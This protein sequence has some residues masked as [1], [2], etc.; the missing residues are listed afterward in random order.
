MVL[1]I[2]SNLNEKQKEAVLNGDGRVLVLSG[3]GSGKT[4]VIT[5]RIAYLLLEKKVSPFSILS[6]TFT[7]KAATEMKERV[8][9]LLKKETIPFLWI[10][11]FHS[12]CARILREEI[13]KL[14]IGLNRHFTI[15]DR[16]DTK[17]LIKKIM[18]EEGLSVDV[19]PPSEIVEYFSKLKKG[20]S[21]YNPNRIFDSLY[22]IYSK[23]LIEANGVDFDDLLLYTVQLL[24]EIKEVREKYQERFHYILVDEYQDT[25]DI[26]E[27][28]LSILSDKWKNLFLVGDEDQS[29]YSFRGSKVRHIVEFP[30]R[31]EGVK[32][33][34]LE[35][36]YRSYDSIL[37]AASTLVA[38]NTERLGKTLWTDRKGGERINLFT[39]FSDREEANFV[40]ET[41]NILKKNYEYKQITILMRTNAQSRIIEDTFTNKGIPYQIL[42]GIK[43]YERKEIKDI[44]AYIKVAI[45]HYDRVSLFRIINTPAR[46]IG[47]ATIDEIEKI[48][49]QKNL[50]FFDTI[51]NCI[52]EKLLSLRAASILQDFLLLL[53]S[54]SKKIKESKPS[55]VVEWLIK[56][57]SYQDY[58]ESQ[59]DPNKE[60]RIE[61][62]WQLV[63]AL[64]EF[65]EKEGS[66]FESFLEKQA[67]QSDQDELNGQTEINDTVKVM[68]IHSAKGLEFP[69][70]F[71]IGVEDG[72]FPHEFSKN[73]AVEIE[74]ERRL[75]YVGM[76]RSMDKLYLTNTKYRNIYGNIVPRIPSPFLYE[77][78]EKYIQK[79]SFGYGDEMNFLALF[80][81][82]GWNK[83]IFSENKDFSY[84]IGTRVNHQIYGDGIVISTEGS[85]E[86]LKL[87]ISFSRFGRKKFLAKLAKLEIL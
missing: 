49:F 27:E 48:S 80:E 66:N 46:G 50:S 24:E 15:F 53:E 38:H 2:I 82:L 63:S 32:V 47:K 71:I 31:Y 30:K 34:R 6:V 26:Q 21:K 25:N 1:D 59:N 56:T 86:N 83:N 40:A 65:E 62:I 60:S 35:Q 81:Q 8:L 10:G 44:L 78:P 33:F 23:R 17:S 16:D 87:D 75:L 84:K 72:Y 67:L 13:E 42:G 41:I 28:L 76:T 85:G 58:L 22:E 5:H 57:I 77:I 74:E 68:T 54:L 4:R 18:K 73:S 69:V 37:N 14:N 55:E 29:I 43:F 7:N 12:I 52:E 11:T 9:N 61:N 79:I 20:G 3:A 39:G 19:Y 70:V 36:N 64:K 51:K 45:N